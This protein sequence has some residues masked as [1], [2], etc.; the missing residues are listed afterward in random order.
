MYEVTYSIDGVIRKTSITASDA[1][2][3]QELFT[4]MYDGIS[5][6]QVIDVRRI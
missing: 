3:A 6:V 1:I 2:M 4:N 5:R